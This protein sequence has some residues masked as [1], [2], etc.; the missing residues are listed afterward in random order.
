MKQ[1]KNYLSFPRLPST[2]NVTK[3]HDM[4]KKIEDD[5]MIITTNP[6]DST[7]ETYLLNIIQ[8]TTQAHPKF[9][10]LHVSSNTSIYTV[11]D[12]LDIKIILYDESGHPLNRG[13]DSVRIWGMS[14]NGKSNVAGDVIDHNNGSYAGRILLPWKGVIN[15][16][17]RISETRQVGAF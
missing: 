14:N 17:T 15:I 10:T 12:Y 7:F 4:T 9:S 11:G 3:T 5:H 2:N 13:G 1:L 6:V 8:E 16:H